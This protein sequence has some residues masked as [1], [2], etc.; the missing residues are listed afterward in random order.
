MKNSNK[1]FFV[2]NAST[3][4][5]MGASATQAPRIGDRVNG[6]KWRLG[7]STLMTDSF[8][9]VLNIDRY[10]QFLTTENDETKRQVLKKLLADAEAELNKDQW[11]AA[12][13]HS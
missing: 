10:R 1:K 3:D 12:E 11:A 5:A 6:V 13:K 8:I 9:I 2:Q 4:N 7:E